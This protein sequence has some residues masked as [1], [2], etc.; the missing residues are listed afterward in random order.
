MRIKKDYLPNN[1]DSF[2]HT[3][4]RQLFNPRMEKQAFRPGS[5][6]RNRV[7]NR[8]DDLEFSSIEI[9]SPQLFQNQKQGVAA[10]SSKKIEEKHLHR[11][12]QAPK[13]NQAPVYSFLGAL[14]MVGLT[15]LI[16]PF[17]QYLS[18]RS[19]NQHEIGLNDF[20]MPPPDSPLPEP[21]PMDKEEELKN[22]TPRS[23]LR[24]I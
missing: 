5:L 15:L 8:M 21:P 10:L 4:V 13:M 16:M 19:A 12:Y 14:S 23:K 7:V 6:G 22:E 1:K 2:N 24:G 17:T 9:E 20:S 11:S 18:D 3:R